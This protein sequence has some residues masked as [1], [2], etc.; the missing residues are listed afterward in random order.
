MVVITAI[1]KAK[2]GKADDLIA[3]MMGLTEAVKANEPGCLEYVLHRSQKDPLVFM[4]YE[5]YKDGE[6][7]TAHMKA[8]HFQEAAKGFPEILAGGMT[9]EMYEVVGE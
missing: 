3:G 2:E 4:V 5:K 7:V 8:P 9:V 6:A 1:L